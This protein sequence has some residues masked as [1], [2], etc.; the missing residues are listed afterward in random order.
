MHDVRALW[1]ISKKNNFLTP[2]ELLKQ[3]EF[4]LILVLIAKKKACSSP[5][6][7][8]EKFDFFYSWFPTLVA[9]SLYPSYVAFLHEL[10]IHS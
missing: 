9:N 1:M 4:Q 3:L 6:E 8:L 10:L 7:A 2:L 5:L